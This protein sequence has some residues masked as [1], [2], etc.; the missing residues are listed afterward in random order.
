MSVLPIEC[1]DVSALDWCSEIKQN[2]PVLL[3]QL[4]L[5]N[6]PRVERYICQNSGNA[7]DAKDIYQEAFTILWRNI[8]LD[9]LQ[10]ATAAGLDKYILQVAKFKWIDALRHKRKTGKTVTLHEAEC[11]ITET[12]LYPFGRENADCYEQLIARYKAMGNPC[13]ELLHRFYFLKQRLRQIADYFSW[14][15]ATAKNNKYRCLQKLRKSVLTKSR[16]S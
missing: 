7:E 6:Y 16:S 13:K 11:R 10:D 1:D 3:R 4:Y 12:S 15:E 9:R 5:R 14:T 2:N 8:Q